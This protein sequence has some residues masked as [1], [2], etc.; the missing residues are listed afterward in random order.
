MGPMFSTDS[1][2]P[3]PDLHALPQLS[4][5]TSVVYSFL[6]S[7]FL[8]FQTQ[9]EITNFHMSVSVELICLSMVL[10]D[11]HKNMATSP[12]GSSITIYTF[13]STGLITSAY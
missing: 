5:I 8:E 11:H 13:P 12:L 6:S 3:L 7:F 10:C 2:V 4:P 1:A 9:G